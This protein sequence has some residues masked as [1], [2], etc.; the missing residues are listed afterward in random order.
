MNLRGSRFVS[1]KIRMYRAYQLDRIKRHLI[2]WSN[3]AQSNVV[4]KAPAA[5]GAHP[6]C[7]ALIGEM[8]E[9]LVTEIK[10]FVGS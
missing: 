10:V 9:S 4:R 7:G 8:E 3:F 6:V 5:A 1:I 2:L